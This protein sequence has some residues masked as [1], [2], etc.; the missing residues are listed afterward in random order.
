M[1][2]SPMDEFLAHQTTDTF[3]YV[4]TSDKNF[5]DRYYFNC[6]P[7]SDELFLVTGMGQYPNLGVTD[8]FVTISHGEQQYTVRA[9]RELGHDRLDTQV[10]PL[11]VEVLEGLKKLRLRCDENE[12]GIA[13]DLT[14]EGTIPALEEPK[15]F[16][17]TRA[18]ITQDVSRYAQVGSWSGRLEVAGQTYEVEPTRWKGARDRSWGVRPVGEPEAP[19]IRLKDMANATVGFLHNWL[20]MQFDDYMVKVCVDEDYDGNRVQE[21]SMK[22][23]NFGHDK[24]HEHLGRP[25]VEIDYLSGTREMAA[26]RV[27]IRRD[28]TVTLESRNTPLR[29]VYLAAGSGYRPDADWGHGTWRGENVVQ[30]LVHDMSTQEK[31]SSWAFLNETL[32]RYELST[33]EVGYGMH[34]NMCI[35]I[36]RPSGFDT[37]DTMAP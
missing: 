8:A 15:S 26:S 25:E 6:H 1:P 7:S 16:T 34:E 2:I 36:H 17:R 23:W 13:F 31:R 21:E 32:C 10:G 11:S 35:G 4:F 5:Y 30:G 22:V 33:G 27:V 24:P 20:P 9:S 28:D 3:D 18:R 37:P 14:F 29:T 19:G 12:W